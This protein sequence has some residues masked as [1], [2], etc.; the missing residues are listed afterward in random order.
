MRAVFLII[1][2]VCLLFSRNSFAQ[3]HDTLP[4]RAIET[5]SALRITNLNPYFTIHDDSTLTYNLEINKD[6]S[7]YYWFIRNSPVGL[8]INKD[9]GILT[10]KADKSFFLSGKL[11]YDVEYRVNVGVQNLSDARERTDTF[12]TIV[13]YNTDIINSKVKPSVSS[14]LVVDEGDTVSFKVQCENGSFPVES[15]TFFANTPLKNYTLVKKCDD[16]FTWMPPFDFVKET[17]SAKVKV[18]VL[19][20]VGVNK[21][22]IRDT[23]TVRIVVRD[24][25]NYPMAAEDYRQVVKN[26][27]TY[28]LQL[29][30]T[31]LQL[32][33]SVK[34]TKST[35][36]TFDITS[37]TTALTGSILSSSANNSTQKIGQVLPS[38]G[39]SLVPIK[40]AVAPQKV[41][42]QN[43][44]S[45]V[46]GSIKRLSYMLG[47]NALIGDRDNDI[48]RKTNRLKEE[49]KQTQIQLIDIPLEMTNNMSEEQL[50][51]YFNS[52]KVQKKYRIKK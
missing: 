8:R 11:K 30:Y 45:M 52:P 10:F 16:D 14:T 38:V 31:F 29:K 5:D 37:S 48:T 1:A 47:D 39:V 15:I 51:Q 23:A 46:R 22:Q 43:Q 6:E 49:L 35:R 26:I 36:T 21:F 19:N 40:E 13:F 9:N 17:D 44:A 7:K 41:F 33:K 50:N 28:V 25:L 18:L 4:G 12:F 42:D 3:Q 34:G 27:N 24:A 2:L 32:D 20:F